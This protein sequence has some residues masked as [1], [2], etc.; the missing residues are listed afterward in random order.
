MTGFFKNFYAS[1]WLQPEY[2]TGEYTYRPG[3]HGSSPE[4]LTGKGRKPDL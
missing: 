1:C 2:S 4:R 3:Y